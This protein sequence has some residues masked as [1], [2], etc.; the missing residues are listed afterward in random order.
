MR[1]RETAASQ[2]AEA[3]GVPRAQ[4][5]ELA[6]LAAAEDEE[7]AAMTQQSGLFPPH[8]FGGAR[9]TNQPARPTG[10]QEAPLGLP[11]ESC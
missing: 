9:K 2:P 1:L 4:A 7:T 3:V 6:G 10:Q 5:S 11:A 8:L